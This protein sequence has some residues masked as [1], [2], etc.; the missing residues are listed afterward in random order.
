[1]RPLS[2]IKSSFDS[3]RTASDL[4]QI[5]QHSTNLW[6]KYNAIA[7]SHGKQRVNWNVVAKELGI[8]TLSHV[9]CAA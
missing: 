4:D 9:P 6:H 5:V 3:Y 1:M 2:S 8:G 7:R